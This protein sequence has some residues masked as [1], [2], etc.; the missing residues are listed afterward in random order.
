[1]N[2]AHTDYAPYYFLIYKPIC[3][4]ST[5]GEPKRA[6]PKILMELTLNNMGSGNPK[7]QTPKNLKPDYFME[8]SD[9]RES[10]KQAYL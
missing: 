10:H 9:K 4:T 1:M 2:D 5:K 3:T 6:N 8:L 7:H